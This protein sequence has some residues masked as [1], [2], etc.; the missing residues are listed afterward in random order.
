VGAFVPRWRDLQPLLIRSAGVV[1]IAATIMAV[2]SSDALRFEPKPL[3]AGRNSVPAAQQAAVAPAIVATP[4]ARLAPVAEVPPAAPVET[5]SMETAASV[6]GTSPGGGAPTVADLRKE[7]SLYPVALPASP[8]TTASVEP[9]ADPAELPSQDPAP[10][11]SA[12]TAAEAPL[13]A[14][15]PSVVPDDG[16]GE[17]AWTEDAADCPRD[18]LVDED[19]APAGGKS[20]DCR[21]M[22]EILA[23]P[24]N[25]QSAIEQAASDQAE[26]LSMI[27]RVPLPRPDEVPE[28][29]PAR[30]N[31]V[32][33][34]SA[35]GPP[36]NCPA[37]KRAKWHYVDR[38]AGTREWYCR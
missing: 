38:K 32:A 23:V 10:P 16:S 11:Y 24:E 33:A 12:A 20:G 21:P 2:V 17:S 19:V 28:I 18:W 34:G 1:G 8:V 14:L 31:R 4:A 15:R 3:P 22:A 5:A 30:A 25:S 7:G 6:A 35:L 26:S 37:G 27:P 29:K 13:T 9:E 36:P